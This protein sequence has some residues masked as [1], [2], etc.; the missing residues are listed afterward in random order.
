LLFYVLLIMN[1][2]HINYSKGYGELA[3][4]AEKYKNNDF[5]VLNSYDYVIAKYYFGKDHLILYNID[6]PQFNPSYWAAIGPTLRR[7]ESYNDLKNNPNALI[8]AN[9]QKDKEKRNDKTF[10]PTGLPLVAKYENLTL[11]KP[12]N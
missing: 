7:T 5:Y 9:I 12:N 4:D 8:L 10:D 2:N 3:K 6:L 11:Y 1:I